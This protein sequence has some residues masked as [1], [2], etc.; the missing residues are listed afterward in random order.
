MQKHLRNRLPTAVLGFVVSRFA[1]TQTALA[2]CQI[3]W[4]IYDDH[5]RGPSMLEDVATIAKAVD[6]IA[7]LSGKSDA[8]SQNQLVR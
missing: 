7:D 8:Q 6:A 3:P 2:R 4:G 5:A 1:L